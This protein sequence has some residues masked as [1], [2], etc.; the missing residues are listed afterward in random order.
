M[1]TAIGDGDEPSSDTG[2]TGNTSETNGVCETS[3]ASDI[4]EIDDVDETTWM[5]LVAQAKRAMW[6]KQ[7]MRAK[8]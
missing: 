3:N 4:D 5:K 6:V 1:A 8:Y 2:E 7:A